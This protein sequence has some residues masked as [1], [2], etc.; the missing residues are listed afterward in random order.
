MRLRL[1]FRYP[2][3]T[4]DTDSKVREHPEL[5]RDIM[6]GN[7]IVFIGAGFCAPAGGPQWKDL[8]CKVA[9]RAKEDADARLYYVASLAVI[10]VE[11]VC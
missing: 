10:P 7:C 3:G 1:V 2:T 5:L 8:L 6:K 11:A 9:K 4:V